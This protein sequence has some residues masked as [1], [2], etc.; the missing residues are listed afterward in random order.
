M[1]DSGILQ[2][3]LKIEKINKKSATH[4]VL[5]NGGKIRYLI[6]LHGGQK[7]LSQNISAYSKKLGL[8]MQFINVLPVSLLEVGGM[9]YFAKVQLHSAIES[10]RQKTNTPFWNA[11]I[12]TYDEK[13]KIVIQCFNDSDPAIFIK[14][15]NEATR[16]EMQAEINFLRE[17]RAYE[18][19]SIPVILSSKTEKEGCAFNIQLTKEFKGSKVEPILTDKIVA[20]YQELSQ[21]KKIV[22]GVELEWSHGDFAPWNMKDCDG[23]Y[24]VFDW[25]HCGYRMKGFDLMHFAMMVETLIRGHAEEEAFDL[26]LKQ[27]RKYLPEFQIDRELFLAEIKQLRLEN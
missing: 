12:G 16:E 27:I 5:R 17:E 22:D 23:K 8:L 25:E 15:G 2:Q 18:Q 10:E 4:F 7:R 3:V 11:I 1:S 24:T 21:D 19:F 20:V 14:V 6:D 26:G 9:G 13:Q